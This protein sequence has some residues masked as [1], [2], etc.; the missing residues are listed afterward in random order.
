MAQDDT[1]SAELERLGKIIATNLR[2]RRIERGFTQ[3]ELALVSGMD[4]TSYSRVETNQRKLVAQEALLLCDH[5]GTSL[6][7]L[8]QDPE[9]EVAA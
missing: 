2:T 8:A 9:V 6:T 3:V 7:E 5:L 1:V 4:D